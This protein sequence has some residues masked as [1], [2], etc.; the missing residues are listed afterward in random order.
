M[1]YTRLLAVAIVFCSIVIAAPAMAAT[2]N[3]FNA[4]ANKPAMAPAMFM[5]VESSDS[6]GQWGWAI[7]S[8]IVYDWQPLNLEK[9]GNSNP[10]GIDHLLLQHVHG[11]VGLA[12]WM[13]VG[14]NMPVAWFY[15]YRNPD[16][17]NPPKETH[18]AISDMTFS[19]KTPIIDREVYNVGFAMEGWV[20]WLTFPVGRV[21]NFL[22]E[23]FPMVCGM[24]ILDGS[25]APWVVLGMNVGYIAR[26]R[27]NIN[28][29]IFDDQFLLGVAF[30]FQ[31]I[32]EV[33]LITEL[34]TRTPVGEFFKKTDNTPMTFR[35]GVRWNISDNWFFESGGEYGYGGTAP[36]AGGFIGFRYVV[37]THEP[38]FKREPLPP[39]A[40]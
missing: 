19:V 40:D 37:E 14:L 11:S 17:A 13:T 20:Q 36:H 7:G 35:Q 21:N 38:K 31:V 9:I 4:V 16:I 34:E 15:Q 5:Y 3:R 22:G 24:A 12:D 8:D 26:K 32:P 2:S 39:S 29:V 28:D 18:M 33:S 1:T 10:G 23:D 30:K 27:V 6:L 25:P